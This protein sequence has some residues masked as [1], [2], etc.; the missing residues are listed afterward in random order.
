MNARY[1]NLLNRY[2]ELVSLEVKD[3]ER[4]GK[5]VAQQSQ[6]ILAIDGLQPNVGHKVLW[7]IRDVLSG[8]I[9]IAKPLLSSSSE[10]L[11]PMLVQVKT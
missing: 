6:V 1:R 3:A 11:A 9:M 2:D 10:D 4:I 5:I 7:V 8:E